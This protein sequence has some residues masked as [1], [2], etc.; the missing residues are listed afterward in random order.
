[1]FISLK[2]LE[3]NKKLKLSDDTIVRLQ[4]EIS[5]LNKAVFDAK[6]WRSKLD[7]GIWIAIVLF[8]FGVGA[9]SVLIKIDYD[10]RKL[11]EEIDSQKLE[12]KKKDK[13]IEFLKSKP[14]TLK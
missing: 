10:K 3:M 8:V 12:L 5:V 7:I 4:S 2:V 6:K 14:A 11:Q 9:G 13:T 1:M